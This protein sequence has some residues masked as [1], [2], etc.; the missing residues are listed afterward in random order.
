MRN[1]T[2]SAAGLSDDQI[3]EISQHL[4]TA[5]IDLQLPG[6]SRA[7]ITVEMRST[8]LHGLLRHDPGVFLERHGEEAL[9]STA[10]ASDGSS[11]LLAYFEPLRASS[12]E[13]DFC[14]KLLEDKTTESINRK[15][16]SSATVKN[17]RL[18]FLEKSLDAEYFSDEAMRQREPYLHHLY[19][20]QY[21]SAVQEEEKEEEEEE[22]S[23]EGSG[24]VL[25]LRA[26]EQQ[27]QPRGAASATR[28]ASVAESIM[29]KHDEVEL[30][31]R[32]EAEREKYATRKKHQNRDDD[33]DEAYS[34]HE[35]DDDDSDDSDDD[36]N[37]VGQRDAWPE[38]E[39]ITEQQ[40]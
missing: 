4:I 23:Q 10:T 38:P 28:I 35:S 7:P 32:R 12:Y 3:Y 15:R 33:D 27:Q 9:L 18:A 36:S 29:E 20:G 21:K 2:M 24:D 19:I 8:Y 39:L 22:H 37:V 11:S 30:M 1:G 16:S 17:R 25:P 31:V 40:R 5:K 13:V 34:E 6:Q 14:M 26:V